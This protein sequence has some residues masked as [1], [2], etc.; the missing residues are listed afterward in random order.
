MAVLQIIR[1]TLPGITVVACDMDIYS[2]AQTFAH[3]FVPVLPAGHP[4]YADNIK[5]VIDQYD[6]DLVV[7]SFHFGH[8]A[9]AGLEDKAF[10]NNFKASR[11]CHDK[12]KFYEW[13]KK[14]GYSVPKTRLLSST[15]SIQSKAYIKPRAGAGSANN[16]VAAT[17]EDFLL[18][19]KLL[20]G[21]QDYLVQEF[22]EGEL[23]HVEALHLDGGMIASTTCRSMRAKAGNTVIALVSDYKELQDLASNVLK[24]MQYNGLSNMDVVRT[25]Q[26]ELVILELNPRSGSTIQYTTEAGCNTIAYLLTKDRKYLAPINEGVYASYRQISKIRPD[27]N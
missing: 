15:D 25:K 20:A 26:G 3:H 8:Q 11:I 16:Y 9:L 18:F 1:Q 6:I 5:K 10:I 4:G 21:G 22:I 17:N 14:R 7:P 2:P 27:S 13:C 24:E 23:W 19:K 12:F